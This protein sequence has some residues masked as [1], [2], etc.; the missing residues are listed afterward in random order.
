M[1]DLEIEVHKDFQ[2]VKEQEAGLGKLVCQVDQV[3]LELMVDPV[4]EVLK[5]YKDLQEKLVNQEVQVPL[6]DQVN[7]D[8]LVTQ[9]ALVYL[10]T[11]V[12]LDDQDLMDVLDH[13]DQQV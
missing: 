2:E 8:L 3:R 13:K 1:E 12:P 5:V 11:E 7:L 4:R 9:E 6:V 10:E